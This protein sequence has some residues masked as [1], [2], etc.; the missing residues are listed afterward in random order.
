MSI[1][2]CHYDDD[3]LMQIISIKNHISLL[4]T[5]IIVKYVFELLK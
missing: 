2:K 1:I 5:M 4:S 3:K